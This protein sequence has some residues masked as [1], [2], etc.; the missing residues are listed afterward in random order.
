[1][2]GTKRRKKHGLYFSTLKRNWMVW[3]AVQA[4]NFT[5]VPLQYRILFVNAVAIGENFLLFYVAMDD[6]MGH[7]HADERNRMELLS[8][9]R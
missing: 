8:E 1:M 2:E 6:S 5:F 3:P 4:I 7:G 9:Q